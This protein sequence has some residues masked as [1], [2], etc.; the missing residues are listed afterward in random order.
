MA[1]RGPDEIDLWGIAWARQRRMILGIKPLKPEDR[2]GKLKST[3]GSIVKEKVGAGDHTVRMGENGH[4]D[5]NWPEVYTG[6]ALTVHRAYQLMPGNLK[7]IMHLHYVWRE[8]DVADKAPTIGMK[9]TQYWSS[10]SSMKSFLQGVVLA[11]K[12][13]AKSSVRYA[14]AAVG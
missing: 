8:V 1:S 13:E 3:L 9:A 11:T 7:L 2:L 12:E 10:V 14:L 5:L 6:I 4:R